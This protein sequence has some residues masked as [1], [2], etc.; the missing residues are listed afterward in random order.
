MNGQGI[1]PF[2]YGES[3]SVGVP[4]CY[5]VLDVLT[6]LALTFMPMTGFL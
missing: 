1:N 3:N 4:I 6:P 2:G 5:G